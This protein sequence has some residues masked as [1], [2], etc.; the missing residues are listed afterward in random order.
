MG[1]VAVE[2]E[3]TVDDEDA[4]EDEDAEQVVAEGCGDRRDDD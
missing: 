1:D 2:D 4:V 3:D